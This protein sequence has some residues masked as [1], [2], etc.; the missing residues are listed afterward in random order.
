MLDKLIDIIVQFANDILPFV[1]VP[2]YDK[3]VR[4]RFGKPRGALEPGFHWKIPFADDI[5]TH[6]VKTATIDLSEQTITTKDNQSV[7]V[8][9]VIKYDVLD[10]EKLLLEVSGPVEALSDMSKGI[11]RTI[12]TTKNWSECNDPEIEKQI[13]QKI[14]QESKKW[15]IRVLEVTLTDLALMRSVRLLTSGFLREQSS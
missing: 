1:V 15:G 3:G 6:M 9:A 10:V 13:G 12:L 4:L 2:Y 14:K 8:K 5:I 11:I 7:V